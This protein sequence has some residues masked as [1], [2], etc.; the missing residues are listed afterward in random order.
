MFCS[1]QITE[2]MLQLRWFENSGRKRFNYAIL[3]VF[4]NM[5]FNFLNLTSSNC[6]AYCSS[7][8]ANIA[9]KLCPWKKTPKP[10]LLSLA[11]SNLPI[12]RKCPFGAKQRSEAF[13]L[14]SDR[15]VAASRKVH[16]LGT[17]HDIIELGSIWDATAECNAMPMTGLPDFSSI[18]LY[19]RPKM[20]DCSRRVRPMSSADRR[21]EAC[22]TSR[23][24]SAEIN[25]EN[26]LFKQGK[27]DIK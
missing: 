4:R 21:P 8:S 27:S 14:S 26:E 17:S 20:Y 19:S 3:Y 9:W 22:I 12:S 6:G 7:L 13:S 25:I 11:I 10:I 24:L 1:H 23:K 18:P 2:C 16:W 5:S 15:T